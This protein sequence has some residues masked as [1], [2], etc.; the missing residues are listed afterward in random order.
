MAA[1]AP[2]PSARVTMTVMAKPL[3]FKSERTA[4]RKSVIR[5]IELLPCVFLYIERAG[6]E[7]TISAQIF[8][9]IG[10]TFET[11]SM[12]QFRKLL[13]AGRLL[14]KHAMRRSEP[15]STAFDS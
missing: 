14:S 11:A 6:N 9:D 7:S 1:L 3:I 8:R 4:N 13:H 15:G 5:L 12:Q 2:M 10:N